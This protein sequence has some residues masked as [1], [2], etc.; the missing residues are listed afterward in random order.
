MESTGN[1]EDKETS[2]NSFRDGQG[3]E[4]NFNIAASRLKWKLGPSKY[5]P[6]DNSR[7]MITGFRPKDS[8]TTLSL[9]GSAG[10]S[11]GARV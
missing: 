7:I 11:S 3:A 8:Q 4:S 2:R 5:G 10:F 1:K 9:G 6:E